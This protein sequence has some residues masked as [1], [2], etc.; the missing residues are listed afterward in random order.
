VLTQSII[1]DDDGDENENESVDTVVNSDEARS[2]NYKC[3]LSSK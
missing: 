1:S 2:K 3:I